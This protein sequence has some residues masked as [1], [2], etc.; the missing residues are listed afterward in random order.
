MLNW[1]QQAGN[2]K[3]IPFV[4]IEPKRGPPSPNISFLPH[5]NDYMYPLNGTFQCPSYLYTT[6]GQDTTP[7]YIVRPWEKNVRLD[8]FRNIL[9]K[10]S[11]FC[12]LDAYNDFTFYFVVIY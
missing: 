5:W 7:C 8:Y 10:I 4:N 6:C 11:V 12:R 1:L 9:N 2:G 3:V